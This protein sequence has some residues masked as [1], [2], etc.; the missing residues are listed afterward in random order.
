[1]EKSKIQAKLRSLVEEGKAIYRK[2]EDEKRQLTT[3]E[4]KRLA[5][6]GTEMDEAEADLKRCDQRSAFESRVGNLSQMPEPTEKVIPDDDEQVEDRSDFHHWPVEEA[7]QFFRAVQTWSNSRQLPSD[8]HPDLRATMAGVLEKRAPQG[9]NTVVDEEGGFLVPTTISSTILQKMFPTGSIVSRCTPWPITVGN[10]TTVNALKENSR[11][12]GSRHGG[13]QVY[14]T[15]EAGSITKSQPVFDRISLQLKKLAALAY[16]TEEQMMDGPQLVSF[17]TSLVP[18]ALQ[19]AIED[20]IINGNG[21]PNMEGVLNAPAL[22]SVA[23]ETGQAAG[24]VLFENLVNM[25]GRIF[26]PSQAN[27]VWI[28]NQD[29]VPQLQVMTLGIGTA[30]VPVYLPPGGA[31]STP[32]GTLFGR[33][34]IPVEHCK[35]VGTKGDIILADFSQYLYASKGGIMSAQSIHVRFIEGETAFRFIVRND[36]KPWWSSALTPANGSNTLSP[37]VVLDTRA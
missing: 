28:I 11:V 14:R 27:S 9:A 3:D 6:I 25:W 12:A 7:D 33:P 22:V 29:V 4:D 2:A 17:I 8:I 35:T 34:I 20:E 5:A 10:S 1:M 24:T 36:G 16:V 31:S 26:A 15:A 32:Y 13:I 23:K 37:F 18:Q 19:F 21:G 30:G